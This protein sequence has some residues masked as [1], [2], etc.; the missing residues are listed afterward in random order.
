MAITRVPTINNAQYTLD[1]QISAGA[2]SLTLNQSVT[3]IVRAPGVI[4][5]DR[6]DSAGAVT[7]S[8]RE[9]KTFTGVSGA[10]LTGLVGGLAGST[11]QVHAVAAIVEFVPD[12][13]QEQALYDFAILEH[14]TSGVHVSLPS[15]S[16][17]KVFTALNASGASLQGV[18]PIRPVFVF[19]GASGATTNVGFPLNMPEAGTIA[20]VSATLNGPV[21]G[22]SLLL[23]INK[24]FVTMFTD[25][26]TRLTITG[27]GTFA[28]TASISVNTFARGDILSV[29]ID[30]G[31]GTFTGATVRLEAR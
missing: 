14:D 13:I 15:V 27:G 19:A 1:S 7:A 3:G 20:Y 23:D 8:K 5:I 17:I 2:S 16:F 28:S 30:A 26:N 9:Y 18:A 4:A 10:N 24:N 25:Q 6:I 21:S 12:V 11:D 22:A 29:D 31:G